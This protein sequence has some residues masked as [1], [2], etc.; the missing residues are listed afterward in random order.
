MNVKEILTMPV[1]YK[2]IQTLPED[3]VGTVAYGFATP[4]SQ[5]IITAFPFPPESAMPFGDAQH[6]INGI[7][8]SLGENQALIEV[9]TGKTTSGRPYIYSI[10]KTAQETSGVQYFMLFQEKVCDEVVCIKAFFQEYGTT[11]I[12]DNEIF[13]AMLSQGILTM[14]EK[15]KWWCD[16][17]DETLKRSFLMNLSEQ[18]QF[19]EYFPDHPLSQARALIKHLI[20][21]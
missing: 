16:P 7:H 17:Y 9:N 18:E 1:G 6:V 8:H 12:R 15:D 19:D 14:E 5:N 20:G 2:Q 3:P 13:S 11:G 4:F 10:I 21:Q